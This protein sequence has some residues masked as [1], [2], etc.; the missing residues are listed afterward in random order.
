MD[1][2]NSG[3]KLTAHYCACVCTQEL[4][5]LALCV[6]SRRSATSPSPKY[7][8][9]LISCSIATTTSIEESKLKF[10]SR[11][12]RSSWQKAP[13]D[14][15]IKIIRE[16]LIL[17]T[18]YRNPNYTISVAMATNFTAKLHLISPKIPAEQKCFTNSR[19]PR[20]TA[21]SEKLIQRNSLTY[22][23]YIQQKI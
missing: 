8:C 4:V 13:L 15:S 17:P 11:S 20:K 3:R 1:S 16:M 7:G 9:L 6:Y 21:Y 2:E 19:V 12:L 10:W 14:V 23:D 18:K 5:R 22:Y